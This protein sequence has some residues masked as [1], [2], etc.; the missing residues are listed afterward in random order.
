MIGLHSPRVLYY[1]T[2]QVARAIARLGR[3]TGTLFAF[4]LL[5]ACGTTKTYDDVYVIRTREGGAAGDAASGASHAVDSGGHKS[6]PR[7]SAAEVDASEADAP[8]AEADASG[9]DAG[10]DGDLLYI[11]ASNPDA[12]DWFG[13]SVALSGDWLAV[14]APHES[15]RAVGIGGDQTDDSADGSGAVYLFSHDLSGWAQRAYVKASNTGAVDDFGSVLAFSEGTLVVGAPYE[16]S[17]ATGIDGDAGNGKGGN[18]GAAYVFVQ[19]DGVWQQQAYIKATN[20]DWIDLFGAGVALSGDVLVVGAP[21]EDSAATGVD[22]DQSDNSAEHSGA[23]YVY[24]RS[25]TQWRPVSYLKA[26]NTAA[27]AEFGGA[28]AISGDTVALG[29]SGDGGS[30]GAYVFQ[31]TSSSY[32]QV[33]YLKASNANA[34]DYFGSSLALDGDTLVVGAPRQGGVKGNAT[35]TLN[36]LPADSG[37]V[38]VFERKGQSWAQTANLKTPVPQNGVYFGGALALAGDTLVVGAQLDDVNGASLAGAAYVYER[39]AQGWQLR[40]SMHAPNAEIGDLFGSSVAVT[41]SLLAIG[42]F[43]EAGS[44]PGIN[45]NWNNNDTPGVGAA[46]LYRR[47]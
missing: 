23:A 25:G 3:W 39:G 8:A 4:G 44:I 11:K 15:S 32:A 34:G 27:S 29:A 41:A 24:E 26:S 37:A 46:F 12:Q 40:D 7:A 17:A 1:T 43:N 16:D 45:G 30:G 13:S 9:T 5:T 14:G 33:A 31:R 20:T 36:N 42:A 10:A 18:Q 38:Y 35:H 47:K 19:V 28:V 2:R 21:G 6:T 22:G